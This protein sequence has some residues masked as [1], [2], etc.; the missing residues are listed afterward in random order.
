VRLQGAAILV[1]CSQFKYPSK[2]Y[3]DAFYKKSWQNRDKSSKIA[4]M[5]TFF[6][7]IVL[8][9]AAGSLAA[10][11]N[12]STR[13]PAPPMA[14]HSAPPA[15]TVPSGNV[16]SGHPILPEDILQVDT[17]APATALLKE[18]KEQAALDQALSSG[19]NELG[20]QLSRLEPTGQFVERY[21]RIPS[22][23]PGEEP[24]VIRCL[25]PVFRMRH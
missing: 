4:V 13:T 1:P 12:T 24:K 19:T 21:V 10:Q 23:N 20:A 11:T 3:K 15:A 18:L 16:R 22:G 9:L 7:I 14:A 17:N 25:V 8:T 6:G 5:R 2:Y